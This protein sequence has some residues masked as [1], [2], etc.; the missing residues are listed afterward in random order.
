VKRVVKRHIWQENCMQ[1]NQHFPFNKHTFMKSTIFSLLGL[2][3]IGMLGSC[4]YAKHPID[5]QPQIKIDTRLVGK[6][7]NNKNKKDGYLLIK[8]HDDYRYNISTL[9]KDSFNIEASGY[10]SK[11]DNNLF[12]NIEASSQ[13]SVKGYM[14]YRLLDISNT[15]IKATGVADTIL[16]ALTS[17]SEVKNYIRQN[18]NKPSFYRDTFVLSKVK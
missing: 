16:N 4:D 7:V 5:A 11:I 2:L 17:P 3:F 1:F 14:F 18:I 6:W 12:I 9:G 8:K 15:S 10:F 13:D